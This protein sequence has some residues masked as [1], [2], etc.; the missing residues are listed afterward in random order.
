VKYALFLLREYFP[1]HDAEC[2]AEAKAMFEHIRMDKK[3]EGISNV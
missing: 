3:W 1:A 2:A